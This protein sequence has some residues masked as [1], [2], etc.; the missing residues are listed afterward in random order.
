MVEET[1]RYIDELHKALAAKLQ[2]KT[3]LIQPL[4][5]II[6]ITIFIVNVHCC[7]C[8][9]NYI[10]RTSATCWRGL[11]CDCCSCFLFVNSVT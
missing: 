8:C 3:G 6:T 11:C 10:M 2:S 4:I 9:R 7:E 1:I 5:M